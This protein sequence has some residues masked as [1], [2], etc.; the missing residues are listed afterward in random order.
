MGKFNRL[1]TVVVAGLIISGC[2]SKPQ[3]KVVHQKKDPPT[4]LSFLPI[5]GIKFY[6]VKR[7]FS[8]GLS[9][10]EM[11]FQQVPSW[12]M[13]FVSNDS[14]LVY[15]PQR[16]KMQ[17]FHLLYDHADV[18]NFAGEWFRIK[19]VEKDSM[20]M[21]RLSLK[22]QIIAH[23]IRS[24]VRMTFYSEDYIQNV[25]HTNVQTLQ[26]PSSADTAFIR[27]L[28]A[29][30]EQNPTNATA[31]FGGT[32]PVEFRPISPAIR[33]EKLSSV[34]KLSGKSESYDY[35]YPEYSIKIHNAYQDFGYAFTCVVDKNGKIHLDTFRNDMPEYYEKRKKV[36]EGIISVYLQNLLKVK[37]ATTLGIPHSSQIT[38]NVS[39]TIK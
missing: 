23:D 15:S 32:S 37:P 12:T 8:S 1:A 21:Q 20:Q 17:G 7:R 26:R 19:K 3:D 36:L 14:V 29:K 5:K 11:G 4:R 10:N 6:E 33:V 28:V 25:L 35:L 24:D 16:N 30:S 2:N 34:D 39:G 13:Q 9:F 22:G 38:L 18:Y 27:K 31:A